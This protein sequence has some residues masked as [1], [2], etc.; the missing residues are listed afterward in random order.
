MPKQDETHSA[1]R[2]I[3]T[4]FSYRSIITP[5]TQRVIVDYIN[6]RNWDRGTNKNETNIYNTYQFLK[7]FL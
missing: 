5:L 7:I 4:R 1:K 6:S 3:V 2:E